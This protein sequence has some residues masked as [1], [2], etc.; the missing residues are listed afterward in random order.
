M[1]AST[2]AYEDFY[3][4]LEGSP[5]YQNRMSSA[6]T[7]CLEAIKSSTRLTA[8]EKARELAI[9]SLPI[10]VYDE[11]KIAT[12]KETVAR[13]NFSGN[14]TKLWLS[15][16]LPKV[17]HPNYDQFL[18]EAGI[19]MLIIHG[20]KDM[21]FPISVANRLARAVPH[22]KLVMIAEVGHLAALEESEKWAAHVSEFCQEL[23]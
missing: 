18:K 13:V 11:G 19:P 22:A 6:L 15:Q 1:L 21:R 5:D 7:E 20:D 2:T 12:I 14:W 16:K 23:S 17:N 4:E 9:E 8:A 10:D 3:E